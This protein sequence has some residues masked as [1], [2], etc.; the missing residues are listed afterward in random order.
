[1]ICWNCESEGAR[2]DEMAVLYLGKAQAEA[3]A[4]CEACM[5]QAYDREQERLLESGG[6]DHEAHPRSWYIR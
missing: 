4:L 1:M 6:P 5:E 3:E 2:V